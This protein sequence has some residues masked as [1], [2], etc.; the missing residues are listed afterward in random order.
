MTLVALFALLV[1]IGV[2][3]PMHFK[4]PDRTV[5]TVLVCGYADRKM[6]VEAPAEPPKKHA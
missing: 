2:C 5:L 3:T 1:Q 4:T 6:P